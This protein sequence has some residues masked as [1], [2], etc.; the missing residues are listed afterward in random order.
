MNNYGDS[1]G[2]LKLQRDIRN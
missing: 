1:Q 2:L